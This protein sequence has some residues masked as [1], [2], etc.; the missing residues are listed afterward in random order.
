VPVYASVW[1]GQTD[2]AVRVRVSLDSNKRVQ[3]DTSEGKSL[4]FECGENA[5]NLSIVNG[6][7]PVALN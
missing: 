5:S 3:I 7:D 6:D 1:D 4:A 2:S